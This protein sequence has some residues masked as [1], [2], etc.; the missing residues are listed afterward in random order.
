MET[1]KIMQVSDHVW[2][3]PPRWKF[4]E[5]TIGF[6]LTDQGVV[7]I[8]TGNSPEH[9]R[10]AL[11]ALGTITDQPLSYV[12]NTHRHWDHTFGNQIFPAPVIAHAYCK[13]KMLANMQDDWANGQV[14]HWVTSW[15]LKHVK[16]LRAEQFE[17][18][19]VVLPQ[20]AFSGTLQLHVGQMELLLHYAG[21]GHTRDSIVVHVPSE[22]VLFL[23][24]SVY[25]N[26][27][28]K[29]LKLASLFP[30]LSRLKADTYIAGHEMPFGPESWERRAR[31]YREL[32]ATVTRLAR[33]R[34]SREQILEYTLDPQFQGLSGLNEKTHRQM[35][36]RVLDEVSQ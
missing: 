17:G 25:P 7:V 26:P 23:S 13:E 9:G 12:I 8:D 27:E 11:K 15:V 32:V 21:G 2:I 30:K 3:V 33:Q 24:D 10:R 14:Y 16:T 20:I 19:R 22:A 18:I 6:V 36:G 4:V 34:T 31:Y 1:P 35:V 29:I 5:P 28:G